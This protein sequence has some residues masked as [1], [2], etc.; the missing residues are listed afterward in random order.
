MS[1]I[2]VDHLS[3]SYESIDDPLFADVSFVLDTSWK[4]GLIGK[5]GAG[6]TTLL[7]LLDGSLDTNG[8]VHVPVPLKRFPFPVADPTLMT[9]DILTDACDTRSWQIE[10]ECMKIGL[11]SDVLW[12]PFET[13][14]PGEQVRAM[15]AALFA[16]PKTFVFLDEPGNH[17][18]VQGKAL[19]ASYLKTKHGFLVVS[20]DRHLLDECVDHIL[21]IQNGQIEIRKG[22]YTSWHIDYENQ[23]AKDRQ[24][25][26]QLRREIKR[27]EASARTSSQWSNA[28]EKEKIGAADKGFVG[29]KAAKLMKRSKSIEARKQK[30]I[31]RKR[32][33]VKNMEEQESLA[34]HS[35]PYK[36]DELVRFEEVFVKY[37]NW[38]GMPQSF[39]ICSGQHILLSGPNGSGK[40]SLLKALMNRIS[41]EGKIF[42][43]SGLVISY[44]GQTCE[45]VHGT[46]DEYIG[47]Y[48]IDRT[49]FM[50]ILRK[51]GFSRTEL[52]HPLEQ[53]SSGQRRKIMLA[54]SLCE[55]AHLFVWD[56]PLNDLDIEAREQLEEMLVSGNYTMLFVE[57]DQ[58]FCEKIATEQ[59]QFGEN[60]SH[61]KNDVLN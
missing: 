29:H 41:Y 7:K 8:M 24:E 37:E 16:D 20:H 60:G 10:K 15:L 2:T 38:S 46:I 26:E 51:L 23:L 4:C 58:T 49:M 33:L 17:L 36:K 55:L 40:S 45:S 21:F 11:R 54:R 61:L 52:F 32:G 48:A 9:I 47:Q 44:V 59:I 30:A 13:L 1:M 5:N 6:K 34:I 35:I 42:A 50:T 53:L 14:S 31:E 57:H 3:F 19:L 22:N 56:E 39:S 43:S 25:N 12:Q 27:L 28:K 18:D